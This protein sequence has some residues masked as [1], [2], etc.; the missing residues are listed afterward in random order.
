MAV[1]Y[2]VTDPADWQTHLL[3]ELFK[4][5]LQLQDVYNAL[6]SRSAGIHLAVFN[7]PF[8]SYIM[9][10]KKTVESRFSIN[11]CAPYGHVSSGDVLLLKKAAGPIVGAC[12][13]D[14]VWTYRLD[15]A[16]LLTIKREFAK[17]LCAQDPEF[18]ETR[19]RAKFATLMKVR[20][21]SEIGPIECAKR[22]RRGWVVLQEPATLPFSLEEQ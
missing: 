5:C 3:A 13:V 20:N 18:W 16:N 10:G 6:M 4:N 9:E 17:R 19:S 8:L 11:R 21:V 15:D 12:F 14:Y 1:D 7:E 2:E 22:D